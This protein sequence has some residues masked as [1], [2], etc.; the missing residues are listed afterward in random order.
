M[1][2]ELML[3][4]TQ[5]LLFHID[6]GHA[7][8]YCKCVHFSAC[9]IIED[10]AIREGKTKWHLIIVSSLQTQP[11]SKDKIKILIYFY[12][13]LLFTYLRKWSY[14]LFCYI[15][16]LK[17]FLGIQ[18]QP[19]HIFVAAQT[20]R[21]VFAVY[22]HCASSSQSARYNGLSVY[23]ASVQLLCVT[24]QQRRQTSRAKIEKLREH[25]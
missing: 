11:F 16:L 5:T 1:L 8:F 15:K 3:G 25:F 19:E 24:F 18:F 14:L 9:E 7:T 17:C 21:E 4:P 2:S 22:L 20:S 10:Q 23:S 13:L 12:N 6:Y